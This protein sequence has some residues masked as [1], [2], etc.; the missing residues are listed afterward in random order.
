M[1]EFAHVGFL[2]ILPALI[3]VILAFITKDAIFSLLVACVSGLFISGGGS[4]QS[5]SF[6]DA[7]KG[8]SDLP[9]LFPQCPE[10]VTSS[11]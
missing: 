9:L 6:I 10:P 4:P 1:G 11:G 5:F 2:S 3:A 8:V 7:V